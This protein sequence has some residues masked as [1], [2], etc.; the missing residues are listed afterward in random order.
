M[1]GEEKVRRCLARLSGDPN[2]IRAPRAV[3]EIVFEIAFMFLSRIAVSRLFFYGS[4]KRARASFGSLQA[5]SPSISPLT[6][7]QTKRFRQRNHF[8]FMMVHRHGRHPH[9][10][11]TI[12]MLFPSLMGATTN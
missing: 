9:L 7:A 8:G 6:G 3:Q 11:H 4:I 10:K 12:R 2:W 1:H 5:N